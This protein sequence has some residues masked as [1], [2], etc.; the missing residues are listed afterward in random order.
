MYFFE[1]LAF[2]WYFNSPPLP[3]PNLRLTKVKPINLKKDYYFAY[4]C[5]NLDV[6]GEP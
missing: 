1:S 6:Q 4:Y 5:T 3:S 2:K